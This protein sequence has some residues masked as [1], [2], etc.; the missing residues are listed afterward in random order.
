MRGLFEIIGYNKL[1]INIFITLYI[2]KERKIYAAT[3][4]VKDRVTNRYG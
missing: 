4:I 3:F 1:K 2:E